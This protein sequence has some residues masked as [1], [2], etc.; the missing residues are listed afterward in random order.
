MISIP[1]N[2]R[3]GSWSRQHRQNLE[4]EVVRLRLLCSAFYR[5]KHQVL[6]PSSVCALG[7]AYLQAC[8]EVQ[9]LGLPQHRVEE[10]RQQLQ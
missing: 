6:P 1:Q 8:N 9:K 5:A 10:I 4:G 3:R 7:A 2:E